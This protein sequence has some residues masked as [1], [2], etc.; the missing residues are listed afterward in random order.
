M[1][2]PA[3]EVTSLSL[4]FFIG[5]ASDLRGF[6]LVLRHGLSAAW[7]GYTFH[8]GVTSTS[9]SLYLERPSTVIISEKKKLEMKPRRAARETV[10]IVEKSVGVYRCPA[11][12]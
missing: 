12:T 2:Q 9:S 3:T 8:K 6:F 10:K 1:E 4:C 5:S 11:Q 7:R